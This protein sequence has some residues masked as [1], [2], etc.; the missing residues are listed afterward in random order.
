[1]TIDEWHKSVDVKVGGSDNLWEVISAN[2]NTPDFFVMLS[3]IIGFTG[4]IGQTNYAAGNAYQSAMARHLASQGHNVVALN[5]PV[6]SDAGMVAEKPKLQ[7]YLLSVGWPVMSTTELLNTLDY[8][9]HAE[10]ATPKEEAQLAPRLWLPQY[11]ADEGADQPRWQHNPFFNHL[12]LQTGAQGGS[13]LPG[14]KQGSSKRSTSDLIA[15]AAS[16]EEAETI[17]LEALLDQLTRTLSYELADL[18]PGRPLNAYGV[19]SLAAV[20]LRVWMTKEI[21]ADISVFEMTSGQRIGQLSAKAAAISRFLP[22]GLKV[23]KA[24]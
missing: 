15:A 20:E 24:E 5:A 3:S 7:E 14:G 12:R 1:M 9:C 21:G 23:Q 22:A 16:L 4:L 2:G 10:G 8:Y 13:G 17:V 11:S 6:L 18:E 19:D